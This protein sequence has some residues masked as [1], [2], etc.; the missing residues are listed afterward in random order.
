[1][2]NDRVFPETRWVSVIKGLVLQGGAKIVVLETFNV[3]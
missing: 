2:H 3:M 1:V